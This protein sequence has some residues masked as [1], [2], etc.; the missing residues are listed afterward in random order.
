M[1]KS[2]WILIICCCLTGIASGQT[3]SPNHTGKGISLDDFPRFTKGYRLQLGA[4]HSEPAAIALRDSLE[5]LI[6]AKVH[7][8]YDNGLWRIRVGDFEKPEDAQKF[9]STKL[10]KLGFHDAVLVEDQIKDQSDGYSSSK[11]TPGYRIQIKAVSDRAK[12]LEL[13]RKVQVEYPDVRVYVFEI[14]GTYKIHL[15]DFLKKKEAEK[16]MKDRK[17]K[18]DSTSWIIQTSVNNNPP[19]IE[20]ENPT[21]DNFQFDDGE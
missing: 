1:F 3:N 20:F 21:V 9:N 5:I 13:G 4:Y 15:G 17:D 2:H 19:P 6:S 12:A 10:I 14:E 7:L 8:Y 16:W 11:Q 18:I